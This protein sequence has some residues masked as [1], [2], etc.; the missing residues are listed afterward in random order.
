MKVGAEVCQLHMS[1]VN[2]CDDKDSGTNA[3]TFPFPND[4]VGVLTDMKIRSASFIAVSMSVENNRLR[5]RHSRTT[6]SKPG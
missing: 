4:L 6:S 2:L 3:L 5:P 1:E